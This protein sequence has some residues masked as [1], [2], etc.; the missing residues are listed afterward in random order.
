MSS[1]SQY[2]CASFL[3]SLVPTKPRFL[4][5]ISLGRLS[6]LSCAAA[7][8]SVCEARAAPDPHRTCDAPQR[9]Q[10]V[11]AHTG[12]TTRR[13]GPYTETRMTL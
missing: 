6:V 12:A 8:L 11:S 1:G 9:R 4:P 13:R 10:C 3:C 2:Q 7:Y 5:K